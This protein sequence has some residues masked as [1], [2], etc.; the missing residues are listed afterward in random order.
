MPWKRSQ[1]PRVVGDFYVEPRWAVDQL[2][3]AETFTGTVHDPACGSGTIPSQFRSAGIP[4]TGSDIVHREFGNGA[5]CDFFADATVRDNIVAN[6]PYKLAEEFARHALRMAGYKVALILPISF[7]ESQRR[8]DLYERF[9]PARVLIFARRPSMPPGVMP[10]GNETRDAHGA[11]IQPTG[12]GGMT[13]FAWFV[14]DHGYRGET[15]MKRL[16]SPERTRPVK[17]AA[18]VHSKE[19]TVSFIELRRN[20]VLWGSA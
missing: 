6:P 19:P 10:D 1:Y 4:A 17:G 2:I 13:P 7:L 9:P 12:K 18:R 16:P 20:L 5:V 11:V 8:D 3:G 14:W 15:V